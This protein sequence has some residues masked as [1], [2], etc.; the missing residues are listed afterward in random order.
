MPIKLRP[1][2][3]V[4]CELNSEE[5]FMHQ[6]YLPVTSANTEARL[7]RTLKAMRVGRLVVLMDDFERENEADLILAAQTLT[8]E[9]M[10]T[11][12][13]D[14]SGIVCLCLP[15]ETLQRLALPPMVKVNES[16]NQ[17]A[18]TVSIEARHGVTTGVSAKDRL[19][20]IQTAI[21]PH[22]TPDD[23][24]R[25]GHVFPLRGTPGGVLQR[26]G[27]TEGSIDLAIMAGLAPAA[28]L[29]ELML[30]DGSMAR[31]A[32]AQAY[33][34]KYDLPMLTIEELVKFKMRLAEHAA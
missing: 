5:R 12:I 4:G 17:T 13:R 1:E 25:P 16:K 30:P 27:H 19:T 10:A 34:K 22:A 26:R 21:H 18:F 9:T 7:Q 14:C 28:V 6:F 29:C 20:T 11:L 2:M 8:L 24:V 15:D 32:E 3:F 23:L 33:A 31:F